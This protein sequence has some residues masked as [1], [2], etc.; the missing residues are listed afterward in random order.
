MV[1]E[2]QASSTEVAVQ[3]ACRR[4]DYGS[5]ATLVLSAYAGEIYSFLLAQFRGDEGRSDDVFAEFSEDFWRALPKFEWRC[6][7]RALCYKLARSAASRSRRSPYNRRERRV[8]LS[9]APFL[10][11]FVQVA[12]ESTQPHVRTEVKDQFQRLRE[13]LS[14]DERDLLILRVD[15]NLS[16][17]DVAHAMLGADEVADDERVRRFEVTLRQR[18]TEV[19][20]RLRALAEEEGLL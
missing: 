5:A 9:D 10:Q 14:E 17:K 8:P 16:W 20:K 6:S 7:I 3:N 2:D 4:E 15:R 11:E 13:R 19:K 1:A 12:R 18:F